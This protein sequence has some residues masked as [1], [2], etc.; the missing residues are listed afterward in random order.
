MTIDEDSITR[1]KLRL[2]LEKRNGRPLTDKEIHGIVL[3][4]Q[5]LTQAEKAARLSSTGPYQ[6]RTR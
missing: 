5:P 4:V 6:P 1:Y 3:A 2:L